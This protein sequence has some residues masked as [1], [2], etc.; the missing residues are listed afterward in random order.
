MLVSKAV[1]CM[2]LCMNVV[3][4]ALMHLPPSTFCRV[5]HYV[6]NYQ[7]DGLLIRGTMEW[8]GLKSIQVMAA[9]YFR[10][11]GCILQQNAEPRPDHF[12]EDHIPRTHSHFLGNNGSQVLYSHGLV[13]MEGLPRP[14][15]WEQRSLPSEDDGHLD[16]VDIQLGDGQREAGEWLK[17]GWAVFT[18][19]TVQLGAEAPMKHFSN[20][21]D[22]LGGALLLGT[23]WW[24]FCKPTSAAG[25][26]GHLDTKKVN[27]K[28]MCVMNKGITADW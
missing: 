13:N 23:S 6:G 26:N 27:F 19:W 14:S 2:W 21:A 10:G 4:Q 7:Q 11:R 5:C 16:G 1:M 9:A 8:W 3:I 24:L 17:G 25:N 22:G 20:S 28:Y 15:P 18:F 12:T